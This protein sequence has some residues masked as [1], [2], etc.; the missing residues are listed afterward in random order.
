MWL[1]QLMDMKVWAPSSKDRKKLKHTHVFRLTR[2]Y[3]ILWRQNKVTYRSTVSSQFWTFGRR[4]FFFKSNFSQ[5]EKPFSLREPPLWPLPIYSE[6]WLKQS[7][8]VERGERAGS[9]KSDEA[10]ALSC[11]PPEVTY[12]AFLVLHSCAAALSHWICQR[13]PRHLAVF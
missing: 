8:S 9:T 7:G 4:L 2:Q 13:Q 11:P 6:L 12:V 1:N 3:L 5:I 10:P